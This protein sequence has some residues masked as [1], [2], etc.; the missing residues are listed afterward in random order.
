MG[1]ARLPF[2]A[3]CQKCKCFMFGQGLLT[4]GQQVH[5]HFTKC[6]DQFPEPNPYFLRWNA[7]EVVEVNLDDNGRLFTFTTHR[8]CSNDYCMVVITKRDYQDCVEIVSG[9][10][11]KDVQK[12]LSVY[13]APYFE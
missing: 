8:F 4:T 2:A 1:G 13:L 12:G 3:L 7:F 11:P 9:E 5:E 6:H 10:K